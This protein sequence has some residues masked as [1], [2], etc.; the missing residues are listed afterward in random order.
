MKRI[1][2]ISDTH[3]YLDEQ[4]FKY[5]EECDEIWH[6]GDIGNIALMDKLAAFK[7]VRAVYGNIDDHIVRKEYPEVL[8]FELE[9]VKI[10][11]EHIVGAVGTYNKKTQKLLLQHQPK[12]LI[13]GHS[14]LLVVKYI[15]NLDIL[16]INPGAA[17]VH[18]WHKM[19]TILRFTLDQGKVKDMEVVELGER[20]SLDQA[21]DFE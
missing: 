16:H 6:A 12:V 7:P 4:V 18:G 8:V 19:R 2:L 3:N 13:C 15:P 17:G 1:G 20:A 14:H 10:Y 5:F 21:L 9:G 11:M